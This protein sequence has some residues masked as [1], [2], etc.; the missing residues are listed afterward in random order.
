MKR[1]LFYWVCTLLLQLI[2]FSP[3][4][5]QKAYKE[6]QQYMKMRAY[7]QA[8]EKYEEVLSD[9]KINDKKREKIQTELEEAKIQAAGESFKRGLRFLRDNDLPNAHKAFKKA[10]GYQPNNSQYVSKFNEV[11]IHFKE[12]EE[13]I[14]TSF[15]KGIID[16]QWDNAISE[17][18]SYTI[19]ESTFPDI[20]QKIVELKEKAAEYFETESDKGLRNSNYPSAYESIEKAV[21]YSEKENL[22][23]KKRARH[24][25]LLSHEAWKN[26]KYLKAYEEIGKGLEFEPNNPELLTYRQKFINEWAGLLYNEA[27]EA[28]NNGNYVVAK[29]QLTKLSQFAPGYLDTEEQLAE[30]NST[31]AG[32]YYSQAEDIM[33]SKDFSRIGT[34]VAYYLLAQQEHSSL[35]PDLDRKL[36]D[37]KRQLFK[38]LEFRI[39]LDIENK[40]E[41][42]GVHGLVEEQLLAKMK[43]KDGLKNITILDRDAIN[44]ILHEQG[45]GQGFLDESTALEVKKIKGI[46]A[47]IKGEVIRVSMKESGRERPSYGSVRYVSGTR[48]MPNPAY[49]SAQADVHSAQQSVLQAQASHN[50]TI[51][52]QNQIMKTQQQSASNSPLSALSAGLGTM[53]ITLSE[54][55]VNKA[56]QNLSNA[57]QRFIQTPQ[58]IE[59]DVYSDWRYEIYDLKLQG[60]VIIALKVINYTTSEIGQAHT[61]EKKATATDRYIPGD[62]SKGVNS[63]PIELPTVQ[64]L[65]NNLLSEAIDE[66][67]VVLKHEL[68]E[69]RNNYFLEGKKAAENRIT[70]EAIENFMRYIYSAPDLSDDTVYEANEYLYTNLGLSVIRRKQG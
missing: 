50:N 8:I 30:I 53:A 39:S 32:T 14:A 51:Q 48:W 35:Y 49:Q 59:E 46:Q 15:D 36:A 38:E 58:Q 45:L 42:P 26:K 43:G 21:R 64:E 57:E 31:V 9:E 17:M 22:K 65:K 23:N 47:G 24:H 29:A 55:S 44:D 6:G 12:I 37:A 67:F 60:E 56:K 61:V 7:E 1:K 33:K 3:V 11:N 66:A 68:S 52:Q 5:A 40:S 62:P 27:M 70:A 19:C 34:A 2:A 28:N 18:E 20:H 63:D 10:L 69:G 4:L 16:K 13:K 25:L 54:A 41:E